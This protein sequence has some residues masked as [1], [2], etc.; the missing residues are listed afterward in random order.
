MHSQR[1]WVPVEL[2][3]AMSS[4]TRASKTFPE[5]WR[6]QA[7][8]ESMETSLFPLPLPPR[9]CGSTSY[10]RG[11]QRLASKRE[12]WREASQFVT[13]LNSLDQGR[14]GS[15]TERKKTAGRQLAADSMIS[16]AQQQALDVALREAARLVRARRGLGLTGAQAVG[17]LL[18]VEPLDAYGCRCAPREVHVEL[19]ASEIDEPKFPRGERG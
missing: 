6:W 7:F 4:G 18:Q 14:A 9:P 17:R 13:M 2:A 11:R 1:R 19:R 8:V 15:T 12:V 5:A 16:L 10:S 3:Q